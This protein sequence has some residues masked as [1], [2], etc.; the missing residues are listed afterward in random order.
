MYEILLLEGHIL[1]ACPGGS[2]GCSKPSQDRPRAWA[3]AQISS[4]GGGGEGDGSG[5]GRLSGLP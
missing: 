1:L 4:V 2:S 5:R 3:E